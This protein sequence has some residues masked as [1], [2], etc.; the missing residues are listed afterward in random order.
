L[1]AARGSVVWNQRFGTWNFLWV[2]DGRRRSKVIGTL[3]EFRTR[4]AA[5]QAA[6]SVRRKVINRPDDVLP[7]V[8]RLVE[9]FRLEKMPERFSTRRGY[10]AWLNNHIL[11]RWGGSAITALQARPVELWLRSLPVGSKSKAHVRG[12]V[13]TL[14]D[15]AM[16]RGDIPV[17]RNPMELV[18]I[19]GGTKRQRHPRSLTE[20][21]FQKFIKQLKEPFRTIALVCVCFGLRISE[22]LALRWEDVD[23]LDGK[24]RIERGIV[25]QHV[26]SVKTVY[27]ERLMSIDSQLLA[28]LKT[29]KQ[30][31]QFAAAQDWMFASPVKLGRLPWSYP[32]ILQAFY[33]A[34]TDA[35]I[36]H[37]STHTMRH[38]HRSWLDAVGTPIAVQ[39]KLMRHP[40]SG[41]R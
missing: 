9:E 25:R 10:D 17:Q 27:S 39:Q 5:E 33:Q 15:F 1:K 16:W 40:T 32:R 36:G 29:W 7:T 8:R 22:C 30:T 12:L 38:T 19:K 34:A 2:E 37:L 20:E 41:P 11:P 4:E 21:E 31:S 3:K 18:T 14:W 24:L 13:R 23:W 28:L 26:D 6:E 35:G